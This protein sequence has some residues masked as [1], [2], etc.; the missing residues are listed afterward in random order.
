MKLL[1]N[2]LF[3]IF[4]KNNYSKKADLTY[5]KSSLYNFRLSKVRVLAKLGSVLTY[6]EEGEVILHLF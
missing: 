1:V 3:A 6:L 4:V 5:I 2:L